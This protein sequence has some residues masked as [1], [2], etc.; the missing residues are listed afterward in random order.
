VEM[1]CEVGGG[2]WYLHDGWRFLL[3]GHGTQLR[4]RKD[5]DDLMSFEGALHT[6]REVCGDRR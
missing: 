2:W 1:V 4:E 6:W 5:I 3:A